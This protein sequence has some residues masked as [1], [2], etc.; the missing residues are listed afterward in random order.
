M[1]IRKIIKES[2]LNEADVDVRKLPS[3]KNKEGGAT[4]GLARAE[5]LQGEVEKNLSSL[6]VYGI[7]GY[8]EDQGIFSIERI[9]QSGPFHFSF[10][11]QNG[12]TFDGEA[13][14]DRTYSQLFKSIVLAFIGGSTKLLIV[15]ERN[16][17]NRKYLGLKKKQMVTKGLQEEEVFPVLIFTENEI[18]NKT[19]DVIKS[20]GKKPTM[21]KIVDI[22]IKSKSKDKHPI[23]SKKDYVQVKGNIQITSGDI[24]S[25]ADRITADRIQKLLNNGV[26]FV[27][28]SEK[29][30]Q[31]IVLS[32][33]PT[34]GGEF[35]VIESDESINEA[36]PQE[37]TNVNVTIGKN[38]MGNYTW[39]NV[40]G[41]IKFLRPITK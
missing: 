34:I 37:W 41:L 3:M 18:K 22:G 38:A 2:L 7:Q 20:M 28:L 36:E 23:F 14:Y 31:T 19:G 10:K 29:E 12:K 9:Q 39:P 17:I 25:L 6:G 13:K 11:T 4:A 5:F 24:K 30:P 26:F 35:L 15:F 16:S 27:R 32:D 33:K 1:D 40:R 8:M 21:I